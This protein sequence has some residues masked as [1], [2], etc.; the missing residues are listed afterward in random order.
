MVSASAIATL[1]GM[2]EGRVAVAVGAGA[3]GR[4]TMGQRPASWKYVADYVRTL[5][6]LLAGEE[7]LWDGALVKMIHP[8][9]F[10][11]DRP[12]DV[13]ILVAAAGSRGYAV[14]RELGDG[15]FVT[16]SPPGADD[17]PEWCARLALGTVL[18]ESERVDDPRVIDAA[19][20]A[21]AAVF[22]GAYE[23]AGATGVDRLP[24]GARWREALETV[25]VERR[26]LAL[27][28][29]HLV[30]TSERDLPT[31]REAAPLLVDF[32]FTGTAA[33]VRERVQQLADG[34]VTEIAYQ[35]AGP[36]IP[37]EL[38]RFMA[39]VS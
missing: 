18:G 25:P 33:Q 21:L 24:G 27:H 29:G 16:G 9:G 34:G 4:S 13:P 1:A 26:H 17:R 36:D 28:E 6:A 11:P 14:A 31:V 3:T 2:A 35:P 38:E 37:V 8:K 19:G 12:I 30:T 32:S 23:R 5:R 39:A 15:I 7:A 10:I 22:H 20:H